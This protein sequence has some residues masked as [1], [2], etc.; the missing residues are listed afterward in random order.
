METSVNR[1]DV[2]IKK[3][4]DYSKNTRTDIAL[5]PIDFEA[6]IFEAY[7]RAKLVEPTLQLKL[8]IEGNGVFHSDKNRIEIIVDN[9]MSNAVKFQDRTK[10]SSRVDIT[11]SVTEEKATIMFSDNG[12]GIEEKYLPKIFE[13]FFRA[14]EKGIGSGLGLYIVKETMRKLKGTI[15]VKSVF[16]SFTTFEFT[17]PNLEKMK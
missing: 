3:I 11:I 1:L 9:L 4:L 14:T 10:D 17:I 2:F 7:E 13:M 16:A 5:D 12:I 15:S 8:T 6:I